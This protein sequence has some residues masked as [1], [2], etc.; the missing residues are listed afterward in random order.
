M[1]LNLRCR[2]PELE[3]GWSETSS[4]VIYVKQSRSSRKIQPVPS[5]SENSKK[6]NISLSNSTGECALS[7]RNNSPSISAT[8]MPAEDTGVRSIYVDSAEME[9]MKTFSND[10]MSNCS[11]AI[12]RNMENPKHEFP[13]CPSFMSGNVH[14]VEIQNPEKKDCE[15][16][17]EESL[18]E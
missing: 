13:Q 2:L 1:W 17:V 15:A 4:H 7:T 8:Q 9:N 10:S 5:D 16:N 14:V 12:S 18:F 11:H 3:T 6:K